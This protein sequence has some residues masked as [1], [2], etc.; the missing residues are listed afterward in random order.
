M[1]N[2]GGTVPGPALIPLLVLGMMATTAWAADLSKY[3]DFRL[4][5]DLPAIAG[6]VG[7]TP[8]E[9]KVAYRRPALIQELEWRPQPL[10]PS[11]A[12]E[13]AQGVVFSFYN[14]ELF[15][16]VVN[17][18]RYQT[19]GLTPDDFIEALAAIYGTW[20]KP[21]VPADNVQVVYGEH[22]EIVARWQD[23][24]YCFD[25]IRS[26]YGPSFRLIGVLKRLQRGEAAR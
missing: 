5:A 15:R 4:G 11:S 16:I 7:A 13:S 8:S 22:Q 3:R 26:S 2:L 25:L 19:E 21:A 17:Y 12:A 9:A 18:D 1:H 6:Q 10:G 14:G 23:S 20:E 24:Q